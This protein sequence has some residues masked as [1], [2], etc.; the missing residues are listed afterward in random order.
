[1]LEQKQRRLFVREEQLARQGRSNAQP[2]IIIDIK[3]LKR[4]IAEI[5]RRLEET[6]G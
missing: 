5:E 6:G 2:Q 4:E 1:M 3:D